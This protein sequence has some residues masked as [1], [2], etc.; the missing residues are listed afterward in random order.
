MEV[1]G[2]TRAGLLEQLSSRPGDVAPVEECQMSRRSLPTP[3]RGTEP[4]SAAVPRRHGLPHARTGVQRR[5]SAAPWNPTWLLLI[6][7]ARNDGSV[8]SVRGHLMHIPH[9][10]R[11][12]R[13]P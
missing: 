6:R 1:L 11:P 2:G 12:T 9:P 13:I 5:V 10:A 4:R 3:R 7:A 8:A